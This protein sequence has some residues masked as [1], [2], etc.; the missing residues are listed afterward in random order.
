MRAAVPQYVGADFS[1]CPPGHRLGLYFPAW[2]DD[3]LL[4]KEGKGEALKQTLELRFHAKEALEALRRRQALLLDAIPEDARLSIA[5]RSTAPFATGLGMEH[6]LENGFAF[7]NPYGL[8]YLPG[9]SIKGVLRRAAQ[10]L[11]AEPSEADRKGWSQP[12]ITALFGLESEDRSKEHSRGALTFWDTLPNPDGNSLGMEVM[13]PHYGDYYKGK[14]TP[15]DAGQPNPIVFLVVPAGSEFVFHLICDTRRLTQEMTSSWKE[16]M[17]AAFEH[18]FDWLGFGAKTA[19]GYGAMAIDAEAM[20]RTE[21]ERAKRAAEAERQRA[22]AE[23]QARLVSLSPNLRLIEE[24]K[25]RARERFEQ[26]RGGKDRTNTYLHTEAQ[27]LVKAALEGEGWTAEEKRALAEA[28]E[29]WLPKLVERFDRKD[30][31][32]EARKKLKLAALKGEA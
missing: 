32:K 5:A 2:K 31:W 16:L 20:E 4:A 15:H 9:S 11:A 28:I 7:L 12:A 23:Q 6:P 1:D 19:V 18:A 24:F 22:E 17:R 3:W 27:R 13:T 25:L 21:K 14:T 30:D 8:P 29:A 26:L 10:G